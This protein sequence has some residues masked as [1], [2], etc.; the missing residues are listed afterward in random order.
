MIFAYI[1]SVLTT[2]PAV[3]TPYMLNTLYL[4][5]STLYPLCISLRSRYRA[6]TEPNTMH[7]YG[8]QRSVGVW[9]RTHHPRRYWH[10]MPAPK[11]FWYFLCI[12]CW[13]SFFIL[14]RERERDGGLELKQ[15][16]VCDVLVRRASTYIYSMYLSV[17]TPHTIC[18]SY[19]G[20]GGSPDT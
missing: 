4:T 16:W 20:C 12:R 9:A 3:L 18:T 2:T 14:K 5:Y 6:D 19:Q 17:H 15:T 10:T 13:L 8:V 11:S 1:I 7:G